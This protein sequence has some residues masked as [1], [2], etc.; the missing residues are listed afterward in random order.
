MTVFKTGIGFMSEDSYIILKG[1]ESV[2]FR[3]CFFASKYGYFGNVKGNLTL[4]EDDF[5]VLAGA[6]ETADRVL[7]ELLEEEKSART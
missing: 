7:K 5:I 4:P 3:K 1:A 2:D 6:Q